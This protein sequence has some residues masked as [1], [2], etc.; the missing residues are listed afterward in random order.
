MAYSEDNIQQFFTDLLAST[1]Q[2]DKSVKELSK[3]T[4]KLLVIE[5]KSLK[6]DQKEKK[7]E[8]QHKNRL[9]QLA[10]RKEKD[11][12]GPL[13]EMFAKDK[14]AGDTLNGWLLAALGIGAAGLGAAW[15]MSDNPT[16]KKIRDEI[17]KLVKKGVEALKDA[18]QEAI[19]NAVN[20]LDS[21]LRGWANDRLRGTGLGGGTTA[22]ANEAAVEEAE[23][24][25]E[26][27]KK[28]LR[29]QL[30]DIDLGDMLS[31]QQSDWQEQLYRL[32]AGEDLSYAPDFRR[33]GGG[34]KYGRGI[35]SGDVVRA[36]TETA[37]VSKEDKERLK[38][39][40]DVIRDRRKYNDMLAVMPED[41]DS[42]A[43]LQ[44]RLAATE[45]DIGKFYEENQ[46]L[47]AILERIR[48]ERYA[49]VNNPVQKQTGGIINVPGY[50]DGDKVPM[51]LPPESFVL[52]KKASKHYAQKRQTGGSVGYRKGRKYLKRQTGG[53]V[54]AVKH[55][56]KDEAL[57]SLT[58]GKN[59]WIRPGGNSVISRKPWSSVNSDT[60]VHA[61]YDKV[62]NVPTIGW[63]ATYYDDISSGTQKV[64]MG[65]TITKAKADKVMLDNVKRL[66]QRYSK[67]IPN[68]KKMSNSQRAG[69]LSMGY[70]APNFYGAYKG[71]TAALDSGDMNR[72]RENLRWGGPSEARITESQAMMRKGPQNLNAIVGEKKVGQKIVGTGNPLVDRFREMTG[73]SPAVGTIIKRQQGGPITVPG[74]GDGDKVPM[75]LPAGSF[76]LNREASQR[77]QTGGVVGAETSHQRF[78][79]ANESVPTMVIPPPKTVV[80]K[81]RALATP[82]PINPPNRGYNMG[83]GS[84]VNIVETASQLHRIQSGAAI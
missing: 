34:G 61:Y 22:G 11:Q 13:Q 44:Q 33:G 54:E 28:E 60:P 30:S 3:T 81:R 51:L 79:E 17:G 8:Q 16:A 32:E 20:E 71:I 40:D 9:A 68:W 2:R 7:K 19:T 57:S 52:N 56:K 48:D 69:L 77:L 38:V 6:A 74:S 46:H 42:Y 43:L 78:M 67:M 82:P 41:D 58:K 49:R 65:D 66:A 26:E 37:G 47:V 83:S 31:G 39:L 45:E 53:F 64:K 27:K 18:L 36:R 62:G 59:D 35:V 84:G 80:V 50:G 25:L 73:Q 29:D 76:V 75:L 72:V 5:T 55:I 63:G 21:F 23:G 4:D 1:K 15:L 70:N 12:K 24:S 14:K 10:A